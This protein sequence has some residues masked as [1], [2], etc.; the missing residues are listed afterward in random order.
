MNP[1]LNPKAVELGKIN[2]KWDENTSDEKIEVLRRQIQE[3]RYLVS[4][5]YQLES[6]LEKLVKHTHGQDGKTL[7]PLEEALREN[8]WERNGVVSFDAL[9]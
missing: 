8:Y 1:S 3:N 7:F 5:I 6:K 9:S 4:R 2:K